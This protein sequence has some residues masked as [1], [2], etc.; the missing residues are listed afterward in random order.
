MIAQHLQNSFP[1]LWCAEHIPPLPH[2]HGKC[3]LHWLHNPGGL[4]IVL[5]IRSQILYIYLHDIFTVK[6]RSTNTNFLASSWTQQTDRARKGKLG[7]CPHLFEVAILSLLP[8][9]H[10]MEDWD[11]DIPDFGLWNK[12]NTQKG[13]NHSRNKV[14]LVLP[15]T[16]QNNCN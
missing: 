7:K 16:S 14:N 4:V 10:V 8:V 1:H 13:A 11:H 6:N 5:W 3:S 2:V 12:C 15:C 9:H